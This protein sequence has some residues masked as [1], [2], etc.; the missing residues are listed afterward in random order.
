MISFSILLPIYKNNKILEIVNCLNS[1]T[2]QTLLPNEI[3]I[4]YDGYVNSGIKSIVNNKLFYFNKKII[5]NPSNIGLGPTLNKGILN[6]S[7][8]FIIR[9][10]ADDVNNRCR[11]YELIKAALRNKKADVIGSFVLERNNKDSYIKKVPY[12]KE[13]IENSM[14]FRNPLNHN[15]VL[16]KKKSIIKFGN[17]PDMKF[18]EDYYLWFKIIK[19]KGVIMN[20]AKALV[21][22]NQ[23]KGYF[24][25][26]GG[27]IYLKFFLNFLNVIYNKK[28]INKRIYLF[29]ILVRVP[30]I[31][32]PISFKILFYN[33][34][35]RKKN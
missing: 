17:Y 32:L 35:L 20:V 10:D 19:N 29:F 21:Y 2:K 18:F 23:D 13:D 28:F 27:Y 25:R 31:I 11:F 14:L 9:V 16:I 34:F 5:Q 8:D 15:T 22:T 24:K 7:Y 6:C 12:L 33:K 3:V 30:I 4:V 1:I 26:R